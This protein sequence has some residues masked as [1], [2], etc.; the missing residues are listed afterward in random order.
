MAS[1]AGRLRGER[2]GRIG[3]RV[4]LG[5]SAHGTLVVAKELERR[6]LPDPLAL[7]VLDTVP[8]RLA[9]CAVDVASLTGELAGSE[10]LLARVWRQGIWWGRPC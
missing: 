9:L 5:K 4:V 6:L 2:K 3:T 10:V 7:V 1:D 8:E